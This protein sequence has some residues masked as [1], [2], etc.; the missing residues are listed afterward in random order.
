MSK[1]SVNPIKRELSEL[2]KFI[3]R[4]FY[5]NPNLDRRIVDD[6]HKFYYEGKAWE[7]MTYFGV[8]I[9]KCPMDLFVYQELVYEVQPD[10]IVE[11][12][13]A[14]GGSALYLAHLMDAFGKGKIVSID[15]NFKKGRPAH[16][17]IT[18]LT[19]S[20]TDQEIFKKVQESTL[21][22]DKVLI[23]LD[24]DHSKNHVFS[25]LKLYH[26][27]VSRGSYLIVE[28]TN[29][30]GHPVWP[31]FGP[32]PMEALDEFL[33]ENNDFEIDKSRE[34]FFLTFNPRGYLKKIN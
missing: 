13:T 18:Y 31:E 28:D 16:P 22:Q 12:G 30:N 2:K 33:E 21:P 29:V 8:T 25:E 6:F 23:I 3:Y 24:S 10:V 26:P 1:K 5:Y 27:L 17:R 20:S 7:G 19:G 11:C 32:G 4:K 9:Q 15:I 34:K 14:F